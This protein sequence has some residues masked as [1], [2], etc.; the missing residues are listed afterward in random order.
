MTNYFEKYRYEVPEDNA[1]ADT[2]E[3][4][5]RRSVEIL[6]RSLQMKFNKLEEIRIK[7]VN[8]SLPLPSN[9]DAIYLLEEIAAE[10]DG[11]FGALKM[12]QV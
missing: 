11:F 8:G 7:V 1:P 2:T 6:T 9:P 5:M 3:I 12:E 4:R 10:L